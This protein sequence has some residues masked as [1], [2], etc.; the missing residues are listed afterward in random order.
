MRNWINSGRKS[1]SLLKQSVIGKFPIYWVTFASSWKSINEM[2][3]IEVEF[4]PKSIIICA[5]DCFNTRRLWIQLNYGFTTNLCAEREI[6]K[7]NTQRT[8]PF[9]CNTQIDEIICLNSLAF[10]HRVMDYVHPKTYV[11]NDRRNFVDFESI[12]QQLIVTWDANYNKTHFNGT[13]C[14][15]AA[16]VTSPDLLWLR[17]VVTTVSINDRAK[18]PI[19]W[20]R[21]KRRGN[22]FNSSVF[23]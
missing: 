10:C 4:H 18:S 12:T 16:I 13:R 15:F 11:V 19:N 1:F 14:W 17:K 20:A 6:T 22:Q 2:I 7:K 21:K 5:S 9:R 8:N 3:S 23:L